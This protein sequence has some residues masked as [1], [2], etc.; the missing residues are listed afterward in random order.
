MDFAIALMLFV[1]TLVVYYSYIDNFNKEDKGD[2]NII[3]SDSKAISSSLVLSGYPSNWDNSTVVRIG[4]ADDQTLNLT[5]LR[6]FK[7]LN[8]SRTK[9]YFGTTFDYFVFFVNSKDEVQNIMGIC[10]VGSPM[11]ST[12]YNVKS[13]YYYNDPANSL[14]KN[15]MIN[16]FNSDIYFDDINMLSS[17]LSKYSLVMLENP[18]LSSIEFNNYKSSL[19]NYSSNGGLLIIS[20]E[21]ASSPPNN[22]VGANFQKKTGQSQSQRTAIVNGTD[23]YLHITAGQIL[24][25]NEYNYVENASAS[26]FK[27]LATFNQTDD[28]AIAKWKYG[29]GTIYFFG[30]FDAI[31]SNGN[32]TK[33]IEDGA[34]GLVGG[35]CQPINVSSTGLK[36]LVRTVRYLSYNS[37]LTKMILYLWQ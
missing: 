3:Q 14:L 32:F 15:Y 36:K 4:I 34:A 2:L 7:E 16:A 12:S 28:K 9:K 10:G 27:A 25:F 1:I 26:N 30:G 18:L 17:N 19:E 22:M 35:T 24:V 37:R 29:N 11:V 5:K 6:Y 33:L 8:Y 31:Y 13:A 23:S 21:L 20:G